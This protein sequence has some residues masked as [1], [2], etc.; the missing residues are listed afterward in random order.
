MGT[1]YRLMKRQR[2]EQQ[3]NQ[4]KIEKWNKD[5]KKRGDDLD[6]AA[7]RKSRRKL[8]PLISILGNSDKLG[9]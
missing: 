7:N 8:N 2:Q 5:E 4:Q 9:G 3:I 1:K 6:I